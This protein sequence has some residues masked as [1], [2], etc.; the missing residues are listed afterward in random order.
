M[1]GERPDYNQ[2]AAIQGLEGTT[3][4]VVAVDASGQIIMVPR[5]QAGNYMSVDASGYLSSIMKG[6]DGVTLRTIAVDAAG[7]ILGLLQGDYMGAVKTLAVDAQGRML[8]VLTDPEDVFGNPHYMGAAE[9]AVRLG[10]IMSHERRGQVIWFDDFESGHLNK[11][12]QA[13]VGANST[14]GLSTAYCRNGAFSARLYAGASNG[15]FAEIDHFLPYPTLSKVG[16]ES[17]ISLPGSGN[18]YVYTGFYLYDGTNIHYFC[19]RYNPSTENVD[20]CDSDE[21]WQ[22]FASGIEL[23]GD[24]AFFI[25]KLVIDLVTN[26]YVRCLIN[27][28][29][30]DLSAYAASVSENAEKPSMVVRYK[31]YDVANAINLYVDDVIV[32]Q[33]EP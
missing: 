2:L 17:W 12:Y 30:Y 6:I 1:A 4:R 9:L 16:L 19:I 7:N 20:V 28:E 23:V 31:A 14:I 25:I 15:D 11:W 32:T 27:E 3:L 24:H 29:V 5:G 8:A 13:T 21:A 18:A 26:V 10:A 22:T 33:N